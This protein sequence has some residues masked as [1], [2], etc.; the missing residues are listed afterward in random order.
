MPNEQGFGPPPQ[1]DGQGHPPP[2]QNPPGYGYPGQQPAPGYG[3]PGQPAAPGYGYPQP[4]GPQYGYPQQ[5]V[6][7]YG[8]PQPGGYPA[9]PPGQGNMLVSIGDIAVTSEVIMTPA[10]A[11]PLKGAIWTVTDMSRT[12]ERMPAY[13][14]VLAIVFFLACLLGLL[15]LLIK[16]RRTTGHVQ[17]TVNSGG[18][19]HATMIPVNNPQTVMHVMG[20]V[21]YARS[22][23]A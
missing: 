1:N 22:L 6:P 23:C 9:A 15:F 7:E 19:H 3:Y 20:Q 17:V 8:Y 16:E 2:P 21:N 4:G 13:A 14:V 5:G 12:E 10:G 11:L 18:R